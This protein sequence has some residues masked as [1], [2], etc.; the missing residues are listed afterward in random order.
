MR[1]A[2]AIFGVGLALV[3]CG[4]LADPDV[5]SPL[6]VVKAASGALPEGAR[7]GVFWVRDNVY[8]EPGLGD[9]G[10]EVVAWDLPASPGFPHAFTVT[11]ETPP[12][13]EMLTTRGDA[14]TAAQVGWPAG[15]AMAFGLVAVYEDG[16][17]DSEP[18][19]ATVDDDALIDELR[20]VDVFETLVWVE[21][22]VP[23]L[24][25]AG[26]ELVPGYQL[27]ASEDCLIRIRPDDGCAAAGP[28]EAMGDDAV[29]SLGVADHPTAPAL[30]CERPSQTLRERSGAPDGPFDAVGGPW[31]CEAGGAHAVEAVHVCR[32]DRWTWSAEEPADA[33]P[34]WGVGRCLTTGL[35]EGCEIDVVMSELPPAATLAAGDGHVFWGPATGG[36]MG[37]ELGTT[38]VKSVP[39]VEPSPITRIVVKDKRLHF[40]VGHAIHTRKAKAPVGGPVTLT[41]SPVLDFAVGGAFLVW[42]EAGGLGVLDLESQESHTLVGQP[43]AASGIFV[44]GGWA[45]WWVPGAGLWGS[46]LAAGAEVT[47]LVTDDGGGVPIGVVDGVMYA[48]RDSDLG[49]IARVDIAS[50]AFAPVVEAGQPGAALADAGGLA[51]VDASDGTIGVAGLVQDGAARVVF[52]DEHREDQLLACDGDHLY[53]LRDDGTL[54]RAPRGLN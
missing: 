15:A 52:R 42:L 37:L 36:L 44:D 19:L 17:G 26:S 27:V 8:R 31:R 2:L 16:D 43:S 24:D 29:L 9:A 7:V 48:R 12:P 11:L 32:D 22:G 10:P 23:P 13:V 4:E 1:G 46:E 50:G 6:A 34:C 45:L 20:A 14:A 35:P 39:D 47:L 49:G 5:T 28:L 51:W 21:G 40:A 33:W 30:L 53:W 41:A 25:G 18:D 38:E 3:G 54:L